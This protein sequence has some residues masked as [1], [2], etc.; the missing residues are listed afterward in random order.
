MKKYYFLIGAILFLSFLL[1]FY[2]FEN[3]IYFYGDGARDMLVARAAL[4]SKTLPQTTAFSSAGPFVFGPQYYWILMA[5]YY[6]SSNVFSVNYFFVLQSILFVLIFIILGRNILNRKYGL[7]LGLLTAVSPVQVTNSLGIAQ[8][9]LVGICTLLSI[10]FLA[11]MFFKNRLF[12]VFG[13]GFWVGMAIML[14]YQAL[15]LLIL[16]TSIFLIKGGLK[17]KIIYLLIFT[18]GIITPCLP[19]LLWDSHFNFANLRNILDYFLIGQYRIYVPNRWLWY[20]F[21]FWP[22]TVANIFGGNIFISGLLF[23]LSIVMIFIFYVLRRSHAFIKY[24]F[25]VLLFYF[26]YLRY[27]RGEKFESYLFYLYPFIYIVLGLGIYIFA[28]RK[29]IFAALVLI[30]ALFFNFQYFPS[31]FYD[32]SMS[33]FRTYDLI[34]HQIEKKVISTKNP[35]FTVYDLADIKGQTETW[36]ASEAF[37]L[38]LSSINRLDSSGIPIVFC[39]SWC[40]KLIHGNILIQT[41]SYIDPAKKVYLLL[42]NK[43]R[44]HLVRRL[45]V[46][47]KN[48]MLFWW[49]DRPLKSSF[50][51]I[52]FMMERL[53]I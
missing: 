8:H 32:S 1:R 30:P 50:N 28:K 24:I 19:F 33:Q 14:H 17:T 7:I 23:Y 51:L 52:K 43:K 6:V 37:S 16:V 25:F 9:G 45:P 31:K 39:Q 27:Y 49:R 34:L 20:V 47:V 40:A 26:V 12:Y 44:Y 11:K 10:F 41:K 38:Y 48:E 35:K 4:F 21:E 5:I 2:R 13:C 18:A 42:E 53:K 36:D 15:G 29:N 22:R 46:D 3:R